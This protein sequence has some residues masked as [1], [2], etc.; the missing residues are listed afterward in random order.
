MPRII[1]AYVSAIL[2]VCAAVFAVLPYSWAKIAASAS[3]AAIG[4]LQ[5][6]LGIT[7]QVQRAKAAKITTS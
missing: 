1:L 7:A 5:G 6:S 4:A 2:G 3:A